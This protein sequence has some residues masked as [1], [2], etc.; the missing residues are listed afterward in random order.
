MVNLFFLQQRL[1]PF[2][3]KPTSLASPDGENQQVSNGTTQAVKALAGGK[4]S[5]MKHLNM[6]RVTQTAKV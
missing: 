1:N 3:N 6:L 5:T 2:N 4:T